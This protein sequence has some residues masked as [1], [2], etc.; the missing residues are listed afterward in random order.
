MTISS[1]ERS[2][3]TLALTVALAT[4][5]AVA[6]TSVYF[7][8]A[9]FPETLPRPPRFCM[10]DQAQFLGYNGASTA[11][12]SLLVLFTLP[13]WRRHQRP[14]S[15]KLMHTGLRS[16][17]TL[18]LAGLSM[19]VLQVLWMASPAY[20]PLQAVGQTCDVLAMAAVAGAVLATIP[21][22]TLLLDPRWSWR[23]ALFVSVFPGFLATLGKPGYSELVYLW[24]RIGAF[25]A[26]FVLFWDASLR[27]REATPDSG[28]RNLV[29]VIFLV[30]AS[31][32]LHLALL[33]SST[34]SGV[35]QGANI[36]VLAVV[37]ANSLALLCVSVSS[38][39]RNPDH[40]LDQLGSS[41]GLLFLL[42]STIPRYDPPWVKFNFSLLSR[43]T[44]LPSQAMGGLV[45][46]AALRVFRWLKRRDPLGGPPAALRRIWICL[47]SAFLFSETASEWIWTYEI[48]IRRVQT[49]DDVELRLLIT[50]GFVLL[51]A[52]SL[53]TLVPSVH[54]SLSRM[55]RPGS[56]G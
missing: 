24:L 44:V 42:C 17:N 53:L 43:L 5:M 2:R 3:A 7:T 35:I 27:E 49:A 52:A 10:M 46:L 39:W 55:F 45:L 18:L 26:A 38:L 56:A 14:H 4:Y 28:R 8:L 32:F 40:R 13:L 36:V 16:A 6:G 33:L 9:M 48:W 23:L 29:G 1:G 51:G 25:P 19:E 15:S 22:R 31:L 34:R 21:W 37:S 11:L 54:R 41:A 50:N 12:I 20:R 30:S 47:T